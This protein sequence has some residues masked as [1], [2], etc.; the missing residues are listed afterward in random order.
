MASSFTEDAPGSEVRG[1]AI[2]LLNLFMLN[3]LRNFD[4]RKGAGRDVPL[5]R[6]A[7]GRR[8][9]PH[10]LD[11]AMGHQMGPSVGTSLSLTKSNIG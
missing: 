7:Q 8:D 1:V 4:A 5:S 11:S 10:D 3:L 9:P 6:D 2:D